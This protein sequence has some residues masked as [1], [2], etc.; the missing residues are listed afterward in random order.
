V[1][2]TE[3]QSNLSSTLPSP[4]HH[5]LIY[6]GLHARLVPP[7]AV[8]LSPYFNIARALLSAVFA[9][10]S[11]LCVL[12]VRFPL[13]IPC[14][15]LL[16]MRSLLSLLLLAAVLSLCVGLSSSAFPVY[17]DCAVEGAD[18]RIENIT[19]NVWPPVKGEALTL[20]VS[21]V[22]S[23]HIFS[24]DYTINTKL[25]T[26]S[27]PPQNGSIGDF[28]ALPWPLGE[29]NFTY[30]QDI[31]PPAPSGD[32]KLHISALDQKQREIFC[33]VLDYTLDAEHPSKTHQWRQTIKQAK[34]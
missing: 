25:G 14:L 13:F 26:I 16:A 23:E 6:V 17:K 31:P 10:C 34:A 32:Y 19:S 24:G 33:I 30:T 2:T 27:F 15:R 22:N 29:L 20:N 9:L 11:R 4:P 21:G 12:V 18:V 5:L 7:S 1:Q 8:V 3:C 28:R